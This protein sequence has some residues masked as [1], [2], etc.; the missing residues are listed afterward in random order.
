MSQGVCPP[1][2]ATTNRPRATTA[3]RAAAAIVPAALRATAS[4]SA[5]ISI[6]IAPSILGNQQNSTTKYTNHTRGKNPYFF[7]VSFVCFVVPF[8]A[9][10]LEL[11]IATNEA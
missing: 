9:G 2:T 4:V 3:S 11:A 6:F 5:R 8:F 7:F 10:L 1:L